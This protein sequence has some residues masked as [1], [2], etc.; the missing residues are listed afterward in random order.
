MPGQA[1]DSAG[2]FAVTGADCQRVESDVPAQAAII[3]LTSPVTDADCQQAA[4]SVSTP[5]SPVIRTELEAAAADIDLASCQV[6]SII[7]RLVCLARTDG[8]QS[9][10]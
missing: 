4:M 8:C 2:R 3:A 9:W 5:T 6:D 7:L 1:L 10:L